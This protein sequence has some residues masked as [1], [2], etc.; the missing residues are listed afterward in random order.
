MNL[1]RIKKIDECVISKVHQQAQDVLEHLDQ[2]R[3]DL[4]CHVLNEDGVPHNCGYYEELVS[5]RYVEDKSMAGDALGP[6]AVIQ[7]S[8]DFG[9]ELGFAYECKFIDGSLVDGLSVTYLVPSDS[10]GVPV[11][12]GE[13]DEKEKWDLS[14]WTRL[15]ESPSSIAHTVNGCLMPRAEWLQ[16]AEAARICEYNERL[17]ERGREIAK[18]FEDIEGVREAGYMDHKKQVLLLTHSRLPQEVYAWGAVSLNDW[19]IYDYACSDGDV[20]VKMTL[21]VEEAKALV[22]LAIEPRKRPLRNGD[23]PQAVDNKQ[24]TA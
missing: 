12:G 14:I 18:M 10:R 9:I 15:D 1:L 16:H 7:R 19:H 23:D 21:P 3:L 11:D 6:A 17:Y 2:F 5:W 8:E 24:A 13:Y 20:T 4:D 22:Q